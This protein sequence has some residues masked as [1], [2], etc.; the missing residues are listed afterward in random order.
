MDAS[1]ADPPEHATSEASTGEEELAGERTFVDPRS[2]FTTM[3][4][5]YDEST[6]RTKGVWYEPAAHLY[7]VRGPNYINDGIKVHPSENQY[8]LLGLDLFMHDAD[9]PLENVAEVPYLSVA[10]A[11]ARGFD[12]FVFV[13]NFK[14]SVGNLVAYWTPSRNMDP[15]T[16][17]NPHLKPYENGHAIFDKMMTQFCEGTDEFRNDRLKI[18]PMVVE[19]NWMIRKA[20]AGKP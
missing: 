4:K 5:S 10:K 17:H 14:T 9:N 7:R 15:K 16:A 20:V 6:G 18:I 13:M 1:H 12:G 3:L 8:T 11:R 19:G 2:A